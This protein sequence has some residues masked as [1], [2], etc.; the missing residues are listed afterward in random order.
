MP[1]ALTPRQREYLDFIR[2]YIR[3]NE[4]SPRLDEIAEHFRV[5]SPTAHKALEALR[6][7]GYLYFGRDSISGFFIRLIERAGAAEIMIEVPLAGKINRL[8]E[9]YEFP[10]KHGHLAT[11]LMGAEPGEVFALW[12]TEDIPEA[13]MLAHDILICDYG[14]RPKPGDIAILPFGK[15]SGRWFLCRIYS[16]TLDEELDSLE[17]SNKYQIPDDLLDTSPGQRFNW[18]PIAY[19]EETEDYFLE[20]AQK[21]DVPL[22]PIPPNFVMA[23]VLRLTRTLA[24]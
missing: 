3:K 6:S 24:F 20:E 1:H 19:Y 7:K 22:R 9:L 2:E 21:E 16:L 18:A 12:V 17:V 15:Q 8:G 10:E 11:L 13:N 14:K 5:K 4:S 23:T